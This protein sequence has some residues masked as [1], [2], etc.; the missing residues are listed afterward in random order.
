MNNYLN[1]TD[2]RVKENSNTDFSFSSLYLQLAGEAMARYTLLKVYPEEVARAHV[3][4]DIH[5]H[6]LSMGIVGY[7]AGWAIQDVLLEGFNGVP[8]KTESSP[9]KH[10]STALL[11]LAN[12]VGT[13][14][15]EWAGAQSYN[16]LDTYL[17][18][19]IRMDRL[20]Y[21][22]VKQEIQQ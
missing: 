12:F 22:K 15:N 4:G 6:N 21:R 17:A 5:I 9:P 2:W 18:P 20:D 1:R 8:A 13:L 11:Q 7:C 14:Q 3:E 16:S 10:F 19:Y